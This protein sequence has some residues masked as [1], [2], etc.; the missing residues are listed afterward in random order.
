[1]F[2]ARLCLKGRHNRKSQ[3]WTG[4]PWLGLQPFPSP[5]YSC[6]WF[7]FM[8]PAFTPIARIFLTTS[9]TTI[10]I[11]NCAQS[12]RL[13]LVHKSKCFINN[14]CLHGIE[15][16]TFSQLFIWTCQTMVSTAPCP[17]TWLQ[18]VGV[19]LSLSQLWRP[20]HWMTR[21]PTSLTSYLSY[22]YLRLHIYLI[23]IFDF[24]SILSLYFRIDL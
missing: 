16:A 11:S 14:M 6:S 1:M 12:S 18:G 20:L 7:G 17:A 15:R 23:F 24:I 9:T 10:I 13:L 4:C 8:L 21:Q 3:G 5:Q 19:S 2:P 22:L